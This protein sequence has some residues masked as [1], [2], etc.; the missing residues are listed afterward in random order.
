MISQNLQDTDNYWITAG[1]TKISESK[2]VVWFIPAVEH[3]K[4]C[5]KVH[6]K[7]FD[8]TKLNKR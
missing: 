5:G 4:H 7:E 8:C 1:R 6:K 3:C 2:T